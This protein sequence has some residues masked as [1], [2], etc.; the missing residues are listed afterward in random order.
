MTE[1]K[2]NQINDLFQSNLSQAKE[3]LARL[4]IF[5]GEKGDFSGLRGWV[6]EKTIQYC[7]R[8]EL[9]TRGITPKFQEQINLGGRSRVDLIVGETAI[10]IKLR[11]LF[12]RN[13]IERYRKCKTLAEKQGYTDYIYLTLGE[14]YHPYRE[15]MINVLGRDS[16]FFLDTPGE[17]IRFINRLIHS[18]S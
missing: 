11:G 3:L 5:C 9:K 18:L 7:I 1:F 15:G 14:T 4:P 2:E 6:F 16:T 13:S 17:W 10:E 12:S 8:Q